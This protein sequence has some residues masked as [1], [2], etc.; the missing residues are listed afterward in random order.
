V[1]DYDLGP[2]NTTG[3][4][5]IN[6]RNKL[7]NIYIYFYEKSAPYFVLLVAAVPLFRTCYVLSTL[8]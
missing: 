1:L 6:G 5:T 4:I 7:H 3:T 2:Y 8:L